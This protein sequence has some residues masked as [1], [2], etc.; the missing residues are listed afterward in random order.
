MPT[1]RRAARPAL[2]LAA[3]LLLSLGLA[4]PAHAATYDGANPEGHRCND[5]RTFTART[6]NV[7]IPSGTYRGRVLGRIELRYS[8]TCRTV[9]G[10]IV[11]YMNYVPG[12]QHSP[13][14]FI[15]RNSDGK[16]YGRV[17][18]DR[19][20]G[21]NVVCWTRMLNDTNVTSYAYGEIDSYPTYGYVWAKGRT[22]SF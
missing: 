14:P 17:A 12:D 7:V 9:W 8:P 2:T 16:E 10:R 6:A 18:C 13:W 11:N 5:S 4:T 22:G 20:S 3:G 1:I 21:T 15:H 19:Y